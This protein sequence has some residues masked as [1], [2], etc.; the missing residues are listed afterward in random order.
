MQFPVPQFT[1]VE[2][3]IIGPL[4]VKQFMILFAVGVILFLAFSATKSIVVLVF[5]FILFGL[6]G[7]GI[8][9]GKINGRPVYN[10][11]G[12]LVQ[13]YTSPKVLVFHKEIS[14]ANSGAKLKNAEVGSQ[15]V[16][17]Q[18]ATPQDTQTRLKEINRL[19]E[20][21][22]REEHELIKKV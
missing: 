8:A 18:K 3:K 1:D 12:F 2:D 5:V 7:L 21:Q 11:F 6:P 9:F 17:L 22:N 10:A 13:F 14:G 19:L 20:A 16:T 4:S 15:P